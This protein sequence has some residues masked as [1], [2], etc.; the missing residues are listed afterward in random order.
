MEKEPNP[1]QQL[2]IKIFEAYRNC[3]DPLS[4]DISKAKGQFW[5]WIQKWCKKHLFTD[6]KKNETVDDM[7]EKI[8]NV[9]EKL[10]KEDRTIKTFEELDEFIRYLKRC[11]ENAM[12]ELLNDQLPESVIKA[13]VERY[14][15]INKLIE[16]RERDGKLTETDRINIITNYMTKYEYTEIKNQLYHLKLDYEYDNDDEDN[17]INLLNSQNVK[18]VFNNDPENRNKFDVSPEKMREAVTYILENK[19]QKRTRACNRALFTALCI[20]EAPDYLDKLFPVLDSELLNAYRENGVKP[21][22]YETYL[23]HHPERKDS[24]KNS[25]EV[26]ASSDLDKFLDDLK[27]YLEGKP[28]SSQFSGHC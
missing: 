1:Q 20:K 6:E 24:S 15:Q 25:V 27:V 3:I 5:L 10:I 21:T 17:E 18:S 8:L 11:L 13:K 4:S 26:N 23:K 14:F 12:A 16:I 9:I 2:E 22:L 28:L 7:G 19:R